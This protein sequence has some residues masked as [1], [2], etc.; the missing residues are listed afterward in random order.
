MTDHDPPRKPHEHVTVHFHDRSVRRA[1]IT[2]L[3]ILTGYQMLTWLAGQVAPFAFELL[4]AWLLAIAVD[5]AIRALTSRGLSRGRATAVVF[6]LLILALAAFLIGFGKLLIDQVMAASSG[7]PGTIDSVVAVLNTRLHLNLDPS[8]VSQRLTAG[9]ADTLTGS[10]V[11]LLSGTVSG[12]IQLTTV[13][14]FA[15]FTAAEGPLLRRLI[16]SWLKPRHQRVFVTVWDLAVEKTGGFVLSRAIL[17]VISA[18]AHT[19]AFAAIGVPYWLPMG[20]LAGLVGQFIPVFGTYLGIIIPALFA[21]GA[22]QMWD[23]AWIVV[24]ATVYQ[25][26]EGYVLSPRIARAT[27]DVHPAFS[28]GSVIVGIALF[29]PI[30][31]LIGIPLAAAGLATVQTYAHRYELVTE[32]ATEEASNQQDDA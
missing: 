18:A 14:V 22:G 23:V 17:A 2:I 11:G 25:Q 29:G 5:P 7:L 32:L 21:V 12:L 10:V 20:L 26:I 19:A 15:C 24:F 16:A 13:L 4:L 30:G 31:A 28:L 8:E 1:A 9:G 3:V 6:G 27:M